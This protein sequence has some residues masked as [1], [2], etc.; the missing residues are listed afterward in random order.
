MTTNGTSS[1]AAT[2]RY[3]VPSAPG[4][5]SSSDA[6][7]SVRH[8]RKW[9]PVGNSFFS[10]NKSILKAV[11]DVSFDIERGKTMGL[12][13][14]S[15][16][17][18]TTTLKVMLG[19]EEPTEGQ[20]YFE[21]EDV[22]TLTR[23]GRSELRSSVQAVFQDPWASLN[24]RMRVGS[25]IGEP[26][27]VNTTMT[28]GQISTRVQEL[29]QEVGLPPYQASLFPHEFSGGQRQRIGVARALSLNPKVI[30]LDEPVSALGRVHP[31]AD[32]EL[33]R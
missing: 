27:E 6:I 18:K 23:A 20:I 19:L 26:L 9:F 12:V 32:N 8:L 7:I 33:A 10:R 5:D 3:G 2:N 14:E 31:R 22:A 24:P 17:G 29:L 25:I 4:V 28:R 1:N 21:G 16:C 11:D 13:G 15:G 30:A